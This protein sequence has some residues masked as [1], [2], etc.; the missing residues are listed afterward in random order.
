MAGHP[1]CPLLVRS[2]LFVFRDPAGLDDV[3]LP[4]Q[5]PTEVERQDW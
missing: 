5:V 4:T 3:A 1:T 2:P